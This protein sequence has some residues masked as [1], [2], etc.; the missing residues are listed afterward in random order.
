MSSTSSVYSLHEANKQSSDTEID[1]ET[2]MAQIE[3][4]IK[5]QYNYTLI[6]GPTGP[7]VYVFFFWTT[8]ISPSLSSRYP[9]GHVRIHEYLYNLTD[10]GRNIRLTQHIYGTL[11]ILTLVATCGIYRKAGNIP[12]WVVLL[13]PLSKR[14]HSI[15]VLRLFN[16]CWAVF[17]MSLTVLAHQNNLDDTGVLLFR[18]VFGDTSTHILMAEEIIQCRIIRENV[19]FVVS[20]RNSRHCRKT[21]KPCDNPSILVHR[22]RLPSNAGISFPFCRSL[23]ILEGCFRLGA[24]FLVQVDS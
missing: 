5:G 20:S 11:Y 15:F 21:Q 24:G 19:D 13:L 10:S 6:S 2:Y 7:L 14:L 16:D 1:W 8:Q 3:L 12:N 9:A 23:G 17:L 18:R 4:Y 22:R